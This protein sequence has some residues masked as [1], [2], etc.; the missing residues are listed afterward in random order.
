MP[1][2][3]AKGATPRTR[4]SRT[5]SSEPPAHWSAVWDLIA[6]YR[7]SHT[8]PVDDDGSDKLYESGADPRTVRFQKFI[9]LYLSPRTKDGTTAATVRR[10]AAELPGGLTLETVS[11]MTAD[12][13]DTWI[14][15]VGMHRQKA[16][17][18]VR[19]CAILQTEHGGDVPRR[20]SDWLALPGVGQKIA[21]LGMSCCW[22][23]PVGVSADTHVH[24][25]SNRLGWVST[26]TPEQ[27]S[28]A[29][30]A[31]CPSDRWGA[32]NPLLVGFGQTLCTPLRPACSRCPVA[33]RGLCPASTVAPKDIEDAI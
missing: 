10:M 20:Y 28:E 2:K 25:I 4:A 8:A 31:W 15:P 13:I 26:A 23:D 7:A 22:D 11:S 32:L 14:R 18:L 30:T 24:R 29:L 17:R 5:Y 1:R 9:G 6:A 19:A 3:A 12:D 16:E 21:H 27:T 33:A